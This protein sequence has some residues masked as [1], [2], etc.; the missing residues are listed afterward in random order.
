M[1]LFSKNFILKFLNVQCKKGKAVTEVLNF[2]I[3][4]MFSGSLNGIG[5][6]S[7]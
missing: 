3:F 6:F 1:F 2:L 7:F 5:Y 4:T